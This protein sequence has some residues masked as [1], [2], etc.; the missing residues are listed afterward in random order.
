VSARSGTDAG[1]PHPLLIVVSAPS[2]AG[3]TSLCQGVVVAV[4]D[5]THSVSYTTRVPRPGEVEGRHYHFVDVAAFR[6][7]QDRG[8]F[9]ESAEVHGALYGTSRRLLERYFAAGHDVILDVD[10]QGARS[11]RRVYPDA[12]TVFILP[13]SWARLEERLRSRHSE[14]EADLR[15]RLRVARDEAAQASEYDYVIINDVLARAAEELRA[16]IIAERLRS[17]RVDLGFLEA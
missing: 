6:G 9:V 2:G 12:V 11:L 14:G 15:R 13:P 5:L 10:T 16:I 17:G 8:D 3:K 7:M 1:K 4:P